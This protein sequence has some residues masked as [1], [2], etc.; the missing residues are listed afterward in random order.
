[1][2]SN[3][4]FICL[5]DFWQVFV[6]VLNSSSIRKY[7]QRSWGSHISFAPTLQQL[8]APICK[9]RP[10]LL[11][12]VWSQN[13]ALLSRLD[14]RLQKRALA[15]LKG[16]LMKI[17]W[18]DSAGD[19]FNP[20][21][22]VQRQLSL[23]WQS[24]ELEALWGMGQYPATSRTPGQLLTPKPLF[25]LNT[26]PCSL[27]SPAQALWTLFHI[28][29]AQPEQSEIPVMCVTPAFV[30]LLLSALPKPQITVHQEKKKYKSDELLT[31]LFR[32]EEA[33]KIL[34]SNHFSDI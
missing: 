34:E 3:L 26:E 24:P 19:K 28:L 17:N 13:C 32:V 33:L 6:K 20:P 30:R 27:S 21:S 22:P 8:P 12:S 7:K 10:W 1:M 25:L 29:C 11:T 14:K 9:A 16:R 2:G 4:F 18:R 31:E 5:W 15:K 23:L